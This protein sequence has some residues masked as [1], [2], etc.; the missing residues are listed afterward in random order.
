MISDIIMFLTKGYNIE[1]PVQQS[2]VFN[3]F[4]EHFSHFIDTLSR[5]RNSSG[6][7]LRLTLTERKTNKHES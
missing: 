4:V 1:L 6:W 2:S 3:I 7:E 5:D